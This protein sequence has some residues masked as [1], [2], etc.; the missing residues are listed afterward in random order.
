[1]GAEILPFTACLD[2]QGAFRDYKG[3]VEKLEVDAKGEVLIIGQGMFFL[4][5]IA[6]I[7]PAISKGR[8]RGI[9]LIGENPLLLNPGL[10]VYKKNYHVPLQANGI[11]FGGFF[12]SNPF[13]NFDTIIYFGRAGNQHIEDLLRELATHLN[14]SGNAYLTINSLQDSPAIPAIS[15][16]QLKIIPEIPSNP[17]YSIIPNYYG[18]V[19]HKT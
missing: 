10:S 3:H 16:C 2:N 13:I 18:I 14:S 19:L 7:E 12:D 4:P 11:S 9:T 1:M 15:E 6:V 5:E 17:N 8:V